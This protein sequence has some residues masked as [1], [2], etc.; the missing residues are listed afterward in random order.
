[1]NLNLILNN[2]VVMLNLLT[3]ATTAT[4]LTLH[5]TDAFGGFQAMQR[6]LRWIRL[7]R[8]DE[9]ARRVKNPYVSSCSR[10]Y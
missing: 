10:K 3:P 8:R 9:Y 6:A 4:P 5:S 7:S 1:L 2:V